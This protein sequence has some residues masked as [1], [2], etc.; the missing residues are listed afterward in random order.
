MSK[1]RIAE[2][3]FGY[4]IGIEPPVQ[5]IALENLPDPYR[6]NGGAE[7]SGWPYSAVLSQRAGKE[8]VLG[9]LKD[10]LVLS[11]TT[12]R[13]RQIDGQAFLPQ[14][15]VDYLQ[16]LTGYLEEVEFDPELYEVSHTANGEIE[17]V[18]AH[19]RVARAQ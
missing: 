17:F 4:F 15:L 8:L 6:G 14:G 12:S 16:E 19:V 5:N 1:I 3:H 7:A 18:A 13:R 10:S 11:E 2:N 9:I